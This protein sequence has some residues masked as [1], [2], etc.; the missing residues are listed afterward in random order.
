VVCFANDWDGDPLSKKQLMQRL[1][2]T[3]RVLWVNSLGNRRPRATGSD[4]RRMATKLSQ[5]A[6]H[7][8]RGPVE[9]AP[10]IHV[11]TPVALPAYGAWSRRLNGPL[12]ALQVERA[13]AHL[14]FERPVIWT[15]VPSSEPVVSRLHG[16]ALIYH[17]V[18]DYSA[19]SDA[20]A[21]EIQEL[22]A[23]LCR[24]S[25]LVITCS[26]ALQESRGAWRGERPTVLVRHG[27]DLAHFQRAAL[28]EG[29][30][31]APEVDSLP[32][33]RIGFFGLVADWVDVELLD[34][35]ATQI[36]EAQMVVVGSVQN[37]SSAM[38]RLA[39]RPNVHLMGRRPYAELP[40]ICKGFD[41]AVLPFV[42]N[43]LTRNANPLKLRE[44]LAAGLQV[45]STDLPECQALRRRLP[46]AAAS[47]L[48]LAEDD[49]HF[50]SLMKTVLFSAKGRL[51][52]KPHRARG[53]AAEGWDARLD[54]CCRHIAALQR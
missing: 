7:F 42:R 4:V 35:V 19:F 34:I 29:L 46:R 20:P 27:V 25:D 38:S 39:G 31:V 23:S 47:A 26:E 13:M 48:W 10:G 16:R 32:R 44:Y 5:S 6:L 15:F 30:A 41:V 3:N 24:Q 21:A 11:L 54:E 1:A 40:A 53:M 9:V 18:D 22:E 49:A 45:I 2:R 12:V 8:A 51:G 37:T 52:P 43:E 50:V 14:G 33:P 28:D 36:P 17:C